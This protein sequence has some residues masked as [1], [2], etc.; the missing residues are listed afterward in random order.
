MPP[1]SAVHAQVFEV[2]RHLE[3]EPLLLEQVADLMDY[4]SMFNVVYYMMFRESKNETI[5]R[6]IVDCT[7]AQ[8]EV[9]PLIYYRPF[10]ASKFWLRQNFPEW[11]LEDYVD[12]FYNA[13]QYFNV[14]K[15]DDY[16]ESDMKYTEFK[17]FLTGHCNVY[18][19]PFCG[20][21]NLFTLHYVFYEQQ[22]AINFHLNKF[23]RSTDSQPS[24]MQK[25]P[26]KVLK[27]EGW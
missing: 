23:T 21:E 25:L 5:W 15:H 12:K 2:A 18:P 27:G 20:I 16:F 6:K 17:A 19:A 1:R 7:V 22:I 26:A 11:D 8:D 10:K 24:E 3:D 9:L 4:P 14:T 13:E